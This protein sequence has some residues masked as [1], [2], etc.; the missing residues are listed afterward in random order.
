ME[1][2]SISTLNNLILLLVMVVGTGI[3]SEGGKISKADIQVTSII[4]LS[5][6][7]S[8]VLMINGSLFFLTTEVPSDLKNPFVDGEFLYF[9]IV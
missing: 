2:M 9:E 5:G 7:L 4:E 8:E 3:Q 1:K 6:N